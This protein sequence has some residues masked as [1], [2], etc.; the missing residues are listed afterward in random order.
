MALAPLPEPFRSAPDL[1]PQAAV[2][3]PVVDSVMDPSSLALF[4][5]KVPRARTPGRRPWKMGVHWLAG[6]PWT[7]MLVVD[8]RHGGGG[9]AGVRLA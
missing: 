7:Q 6:E 3:L 1:V 4:S 9:V 5:S 2:G 8:L